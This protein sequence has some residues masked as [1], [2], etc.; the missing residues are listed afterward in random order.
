MRYDHNTLPRIGAAGKTPLAAAVGALLLGGFFAFVG[1]AHVHSAPPAHQAPTLAD[2]TVVTLEGVTYGRER[3]FGG[4]SIEQVPGMGDATPDTQDAIILWTRA[5]RPAA[6]GN[7]RVGLQPNLVHIFD[8]AG[9]ECI[10]YEAMAQTR[11]LPNNGHAFMLYA[12]P[13]RS[14]EFSVEISYSYDPRHP[15]AVKFRVVNPHPVR[16]SPYTPTPAPITR[17]DA[18]LEVTLDGLHQMPTP[19]DGGGPR[20]RMMML[21]RIQY[22]HTMAGFHY[23][24]HGQV[25]QEWLPTE[26]LITDS[27]GNVYSSEASNLYQPGRYPLT[28][29]RSDRDEPLKIGAWFYR[30][31][32]ATFAPQ[33]TIALNNL[34]MHL[35]SYLHTPGATARLGDLTLE[36]SEVGEV[37]CVGK[38]T[39]VKLNVYG[40]DPHLA[41]LMQVRNER[42]KSANGI[43]PNELAKWITGTMRAPEKFRDEET[44]NPAHRCAE[45]L[46]DLPRGTSRISLTIAVN[47]A[48]YFEFTPTP[49]VL[50]DLPVR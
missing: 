13:R 2:G 35:G 3:R 24:F 5:V 21:S 20:D 46:M 47:R 38:R 50:N 31:A 12:W 26:A 36:M 19:M 49:T 8:D 34:P 30:T 45:F 37:E 29:Y 1:S 11:Y 16:T 39:M 41:L 7:A 4:M 14:A 22:L 28:Y 9:R 25:T 48:H 42:G 27:T 33:E 40:G 43:G 6:G 23:R 32:D 10:S 17:R 44:A 15:A 18:D